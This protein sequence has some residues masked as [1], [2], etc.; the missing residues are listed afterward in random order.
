MRRAS[1]QIFAAN[2]ISGMNLSMEGTLLVSYQAVFR[3]N[4]RALTF[5]QTPWFE[6]N[7][8]R[9]L[10]CFWPQ[11]RRVS[12]QIFIA[13]VLTPINLSMEGTLLVSAVGRMQM[14][15][16]GARLSHCHGDASFFCLRAGQGFLKTCFCGNRLD[17]D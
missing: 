11:M 3:G 6:T 12:I 2:T 17:I 8:L 13:V 7:N 16:V 9:A 15:I 14:H 5:F 4:P 10:P 1:F